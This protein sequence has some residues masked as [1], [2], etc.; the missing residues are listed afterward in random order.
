MTVLRYAR[1]ARACLQ[2]SRVRGRS[3]ASPAS[4][5]AARGPTS[6]ASSSRKR[7]RLLDACK[8]AL[9]TRAYLGTVVED[10]TE[11]LGESQEGHVTHRR[12]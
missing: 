10:L 5:A 12:H 7:P 3:A 4:H 6:R 11:A 8:R 1:V 2:A 9:A